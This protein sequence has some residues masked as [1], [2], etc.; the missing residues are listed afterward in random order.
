MVKRPSLL[1]ET[2]S[3]GEVE[4]IVQHPCVYMDRRLAHLAR[5]RLQ[6]ISLPKRD[7][8]FLYKHLQASGLGRNERFLDKDENF[9]LNCI[10]K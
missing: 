7:E 10:V 2:R 6:K 9:K 8:I 5:S 4:L 1:S 3:C